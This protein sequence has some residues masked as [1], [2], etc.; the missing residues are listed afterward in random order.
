VA[1]TLLWSPTLLVTTLGN[2]TVLEGS[3]AMRIGDICSRTVSR[4]GRHTNILDAAR[5]MREEHVGDLVVVDDRGGK[6]VPVGVVTDR[7]IVVGILARDGE[8]LRVL[9]VGDVIQGTLV[10]AT[11]DEDLSPVLR[12]MRSSGVRRVPVVDG[13]GA[14]AGVLSIDD[15]V[16]ALSKEIAEVAALVS[17]QAGREPERRP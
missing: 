2:P 12:R 6:A 15:V 9:E 10:T 7:D 5:S 11:E 17:G 1:R 8:H 4:V 16:P 13:E 14:L 3:A